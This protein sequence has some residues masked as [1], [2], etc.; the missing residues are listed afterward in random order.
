MT[1]KSLFWGMPAALTALLSHPAMAADA[2]APKPKPSLPPPMEIVLVESGDV[3]SEKLSLGEHRL[4]GGI[5][6]PLGKSHCVAQARFAQFP[7]GALE[8]PSRRPEF[9][10]LRKRPM[11]L[12][13]RLSRRC[14]R[15]ENRTR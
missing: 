2:P 6:G 13:H 10:R 15:N 11:P 3:S 5:R 7:R 14:H 4:S 9:L 12:G 8:R 1:L